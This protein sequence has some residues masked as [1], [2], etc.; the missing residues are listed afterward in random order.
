MLRLPISGDFESG[1]PVRRYSVSLPHFRLFST[2]EIELLGKTHRKWSIS[3]K[4]REFFD[5]NSYFR[6]K[7]ALESGRKLEFFWGP[8]IVY[9]SRVRRYLLAYRYE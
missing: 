1:I 5:K 7:F 8:P 2:P 9:L 6:H 3:K 4:L